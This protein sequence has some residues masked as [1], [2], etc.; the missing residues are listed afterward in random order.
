MSRHHPADVR[1]DYEPARDARLAVK[2]LGLFALGGVLASPVV[3]CFLYYTAE[4]SWQSGGV[5]SQ[6]YVPK[7]PINEKV[8]TKDHY[9][10]V[11]GGMSRWLGCN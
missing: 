6:T 5:I 4:S 2:M 11:E 9:F 1:K 8:N 3:A 7:L 10:C